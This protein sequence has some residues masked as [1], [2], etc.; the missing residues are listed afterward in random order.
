ML[1]GNVFARFA[2]AK[3]VVDMFDQARGSIDARDSQRIVVEFDA[4]RAG[5][6]ETIA[7]SACRSF[8]DVGLLP[9]TMNVTDSVAR[10][11][12]RDMAA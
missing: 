12:L 10:F 11:T 7:E 9:L 2:A 4:T 8:R 6:P 1:D 3:S 5:H